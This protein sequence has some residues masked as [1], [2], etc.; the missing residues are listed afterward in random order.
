MDRTG[1]QVFSRAA[2]PLDEHGRIALRDIRHDGEDLA[3][4]LALADHVLERVLMLDL[5]PELLE[6]RQI[7]KRFHGPQQLPLGVAQHGGAQGEGNG[8]AAEV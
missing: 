8:A 7:A 5:A 3:E 6:C 4:R 1:Q 2:G